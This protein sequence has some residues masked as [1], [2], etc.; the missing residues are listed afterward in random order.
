MEVNKRFQQAGLTRGVPGSRSLKEAATDEVNDFQ[1]VPFPEG[2]LGP[3]LARD[4]V[5]IEF[6]GD[7]ILLHAQLLYQ[8]GER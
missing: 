4:D 5:V 8:G 2:R 6:D 1:P 7:A 3:Q